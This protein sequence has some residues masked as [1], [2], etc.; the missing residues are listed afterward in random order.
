MS[1]TIDAIADRA[2]PARMVRRQRRRIGD[3]VRHLREV[4]M[5]S[6][7]E[8]YD[9]ATDKAQGL[10]SGAREGMQSAAEGV[11]QAPD[12]LKRQTQG[13]PIAVGLI[14]FGAGALAAAVIPSSRVERQ[15]ASRLR[16]EAE[17]A[18]QQ[19]KQAGQE[20]AAEVKESATDAVEQLQSS[21]G[22]SGQ[23]LADRARTAAEDVKQQA[24]EARD[25]V[26]SEMDR[27]AGA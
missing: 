18:V 11:R 24:S 23:Q 5:G 14:A 8:A 27:P 2:S 22:E 19:L 12:A 16:E 9:S 7:E 4:V 13:S 17:P 15:T 1:G 25:E 20:V 6:A 21:A 3:R 10:A 26:T